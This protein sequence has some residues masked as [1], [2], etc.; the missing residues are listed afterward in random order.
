MA[1]AP[2]AHFQL[3]RILVMSLSVTTY[4]PNYKHNYTLW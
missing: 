3:Q 1:A 2:P 4:G